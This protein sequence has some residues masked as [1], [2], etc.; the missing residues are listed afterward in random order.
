MCSED[1]DDEDEDE[2]KRLDG[3]LLG[4]LSINW[5]IIPFNSVMG[6]SNRGIREGIKGSLADVY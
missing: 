1:V 3:K 2:D 6:Y 5:I 4:H